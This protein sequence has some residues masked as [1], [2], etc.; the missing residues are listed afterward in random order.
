MR[1]EEP[2]GVNE[3]KLGSGGHLSLPLERRI[4]LHVVLSGEGQNIL[5]VPPFHGFILP[6]LLSQA[7]NGDEA[8]LLKQT[9]PV[10]GPLFV[11]VVLSPLQRYCCRKENDG[12]QSCQRLDKVLSRF[13]RKMLGNLQRHDLIEGRV[14]P[15]RMFQIDGDKP[16]RRNLQHFRRHVVPIDANHV[17]DAPFPEYRQ[18]R[19][20]AAADIDDPL[21]SDQ[22][23]NQRNNRSC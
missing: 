12:S 16:V 20:D 8:S 1:S 13:G 11:D 2:P 23:E 7:I 6:D 15:K 3:G 21:R 22:L 5:G 14:K 9:R 10:V 4:C 17:I 18:P 19:A